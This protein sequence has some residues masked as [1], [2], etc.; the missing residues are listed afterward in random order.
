MFGM[1]TI[2]LGI[3]PHSSF[4]LSHILCLQLN[5]IMAALRNRCGHYVYVMWFLLWPPYVIGQVIYIFILWFLHLSFFP[6]LTSA[7]EGDWMST[8]LPHMMWP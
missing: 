1:A 4:F 8:I 3:D 6:R 7:V 5:L 2:R